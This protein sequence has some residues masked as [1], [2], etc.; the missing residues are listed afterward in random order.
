MAAAENPSPTPLS[1]EAPRDRKDGVRTHSAQAHTD[2]L[3]LYRRG[4]CIL[5][6][7]KQRKQHVGFG[8]TAATVFLCL[9]LGLWFR[10]CPTAPSPLPTLQSPPLTVAL[11]C[12]H[13]CLPL[14]CGEFSPRVPTSLH[15]ERSRSGFPSSPPLFHPGGA[16]THGALE[17]PRLSILQEC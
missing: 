9:L 1:S 15:P 16:P 8:Y 6:K 5:S 2:T 4:G 13:L 11:G 14:L 3:S 17:L 12:H 7:L 10:A